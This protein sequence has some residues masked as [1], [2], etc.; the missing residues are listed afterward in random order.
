VTYLNAVYDQL[1]KKSD[2]MDNEMKEIY[3]NYPL[4][5]EILESWKKVNT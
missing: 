1:Q 5:R 2:A 3:L 4:P